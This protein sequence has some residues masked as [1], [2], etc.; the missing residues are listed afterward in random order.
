MKEVLTKK[1]F[2]RKLVKK[3]HFLLKRRK[4][5]KTKNNRK[6]Y[7]REKSAVCIEI[8]KRGS[9]SKKEHKENALA[10]GAEEGRD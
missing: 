8:C 9:S 7:L 1:V 4:K 2:P 6:N 10:S 3:L 5:L